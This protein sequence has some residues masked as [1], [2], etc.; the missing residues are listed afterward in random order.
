[1]LFQRLEKNHGGVPEE[2]L[3]ITDVAGEHGVAGMPGLGSDLEG[4]HSSLHGACSKAGAEAVT[5][6]AGRF[7]PRS[8][9]AIADDQAHRFVGQAFDGDAPVAINPPKYRPVFDAGGTKPEV[10]GGD[11]AP[12]RPAERDADLPPDAILVRLRSA[13]GDGHAL[14]DPLDVRAV[15]SDQLPSS[16]PASEADEKQRPVADVLHAA[17]GGPQDGEEVVP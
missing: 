4:R 12:F 13:D 9:D 1:M 7:E 14:A 16:E 15:Q 2:Q 5:G 17:S 3:T 6:V 10:E 8:N 11:R